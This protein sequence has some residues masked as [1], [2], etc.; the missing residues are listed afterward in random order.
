M[1][2]E[3]AESPKNQTSSSATSGEVQTEFEPELVG[4]SGSD[5]KASDS[6]EG[7]NNGGSDSSGWFI[8][9]CNLCFNEFRVCFPREVLR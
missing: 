3:M 1:L 9:L 2:P 7:V 8:L 5:D 6:R 4:G